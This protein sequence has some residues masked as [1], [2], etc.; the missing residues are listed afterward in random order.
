[1]GSLMSRNWLNF[2]KRGVPIVGIRIGQGRYSGLVDTGA[3]ISMVSPL[4]SI[5]LGLANVGQQSV[6]GITGKIE[7]A[8]TVDLPQVGFGAIGLGVVRA[9]IF[10]VRRIGLPIDLIMGVNAFRGRRLQFDFKDERIYLL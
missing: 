9:M 3:H 6:I 1:M 8:P 2:E 10:E 4:I 7:T 5:R